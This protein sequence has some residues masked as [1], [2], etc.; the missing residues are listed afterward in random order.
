MYRG[1]RQ[2]RPLIK[3]LKRALNKTN[4]GRYKPAPLMLA[5]IYYLHSGLIFHPLQYPKVAFE[6]HK[7]RRRYQQQ[8]TCSGDRRFYVF[9]N[10]DPCALWE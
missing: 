7:K 1:A 5:C 9:C 10:Y 3:L 8:T 4:P 6:E 2:V